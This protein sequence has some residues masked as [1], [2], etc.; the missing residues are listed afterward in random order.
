MRGASPIGAVA[1]S[2]EALSHALESGDPDLTGQAYLVLGKSQFDNKDGA[3][4]VE[5]LELAAA[6]FQESGSLAGQ[7]TAEIE[8]GRVATNNSE[9]ERASFYLR[10][11]LRH[12]STALED[13]TPGS[14]AWK[15]MTALKAEGL[16]L[17]ANV[18]RYGGNIEEAIGSLEASLDLWRLLESPQGETK[19]LTNLGDLH[20]TQ[21]RYHVATQVLHQ[22]YTI[23][24]TLNDPRSEAFILNS[25]G[26]LHEAD[27]NL[28]MAIEVMRSAVAAAKLT[29]DIRLEHGSELNLGTFLVMNNE[30]GDASAHLTHA[31]KLARELNSRSGELSAH[32]SLGQL[33]MKQGRL[34]AAAESFRMSLEL[35]LAV[36]DQPGELEARHHLGQLHTLRNEGPAALNQLTIALGL[37]RKTGSRREEELVF[38]A[39]GALARQE[40]QF[41]QALEHY[42]EFIRLRDQRV[43]AER[44]AQTSEIAGAL[45]QQRVRTE[46]AASRAR[47][48]EA[49]NAQQEAERRTDARTKD[50]EAAQVEVVA[51]L[52]LAAE[53]RD[54]TTGEHTKRVGRVSK[55]IALEL[56]WSAEDAELLGLAARL[57]DVGKIGISDTILLKEGP[58]TNEEHLKMQEHTTNGGAILAGGQSKLMRLAHEIALTH[59][60][61]WNGRGYPAKL[62]GDRIPQSGRIVAVADVFDAL[63]QKRPY[64]PPWEVQLAIYEISTLAGSHFDPDIANAAARILS[65]ADTELG[66]EIGND[67]DDFKRAVLAHANIHGHGD[68]EAIARLVRS[69][70]EDLEASKRELIEAKEAFERMSLI[71]VL[72]GLPNRR[73]FE[74]DLRALADE[75]RS[76]LPEHR[77]VLI[78]ADLDNLKLINDT[79]GHSAGDGLL[80]EFATL[81]RQHYQNCGTVYR[82]GGDEFCILVPGEHPE[83]LHDLGVI[84][85]ALRDRFA[86]TGVSAGTATLPEDTDDTEVLRRLSDER[87][88]AVK[89]G[90]H[91]TRATD[92]RGRPLPA[93]HPGDEPA[94]L[95]QRS[96]TDRA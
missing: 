65:L 34:D 62:Q 14:E 67:E 88:Y 80:C 46:A 29:H 40:G 73:A 36:G 17:L 50:L 59:H 85:E 27:G 10:N 5:T 95:P 22:A 18:Q 19:C 76:G 48:E 44:R 33:H 70:T 75:A 2:R 57:H 92:R 63:T 24:Q 87:M 8:V 78:S 15:T 35:A 1:L 37:A 52:A 9:F 93:E 13:L 23:N 89:A 82:V 61:K 39:L 56:G 6:S 91:N 94:A 72:T 20:L 60:E 41:E 84:G 16:N 7:A 55:K 21:T 58:L 31:L 69:R 3:E 11:C 42:L 64:K 54:D 68:E 77:L 28:P 45:E 32:D 66:E 38:E 79:Q 43:S 53:Y 25:L 26:R 86:N 71:D 96:T 83:A 47:T 90:R 49:Q 81:A 30:L 51:R 4:A 74:E 12:A